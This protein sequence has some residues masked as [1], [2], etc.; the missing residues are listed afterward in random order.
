[1]RRNL[2]WPVLVKEFR[3]QL[4]GVRAALFLTI[5]VGMLLIALRLAYNSIIERLDF[6][7]P[8]ASAQIGQAL[9][10]ALAVAIQTLTV[11]LAPATTV[12]AISSEHERR[13]YDLIVTTPLSA[14]Q[15]LLSKLLAGLAFLGLLFIAALP[16]FSIVML[17]GGMQL[18]DLGRIALTVLISAITFG[19]LGLCCSALARQTYSATL[20]SY[21]FVIAL[22]GGTLFIANVAAALNPVGTAP[23][24]YVVANPLSAIAAALAD[25]QPPDTLSAGTLRPLALIGLLTQGI[26]SGA[27]ADQVVLPIYRITWILY[28]G[29]CIPLFWLSLHAVRPYGRWRLTRSDLVMAG[30][31][32]GYLLLVWWQRFWWFA[33]LG[34]MEFQ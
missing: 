10:I 1:M 16:L 34:L 24:S 28:L 11:F 30:I 15:L 19:M 6:G 32:I 13:T 27:G 7:A 25:V 23:A 9:F 18:L 3:V 8:L 22:V 33:G 5:Y 12:N 17:F 14:S 29:F 4:R 20:F 21:A 31:F 2:F 26:T